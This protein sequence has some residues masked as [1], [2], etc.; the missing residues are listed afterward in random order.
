MIL[1]AEDDLKIAKLIIH[2]LRKDGY[3]VDHAKDGEEALMYCSINTYDI[4]ILDWMMPIMNGIEAC[5]ELRKR[6]I[7]SGIIMLTAK[8]TLEDKI[9]GLDSGADD[10]LIKPFEYKELFARIKAL[11]RRSKQ[12]I[13]NDILKKGLFSINRA[14]QSAYYNQHQLMLSKKEYQLFSLLIENAPNVVPRSTIIDRVWGVDGEISDN[15]L[16]AFIR[17]L[18]M[19]VDKVVDQKVIISVRGIGYRMEV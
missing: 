12:V 9:I 15:N 11:G 7:N 1:I 14:L 3:E 6:G 16:D 10:Y 17:L 18:R 19:K 5:V 4:I 2:L 8:D 13:Q